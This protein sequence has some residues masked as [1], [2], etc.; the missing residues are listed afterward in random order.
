MIV[1]SLPAENEMM[2]AFLHRDASFDGIFFTGVRTTGIFCLPS[3]PARKPKPENVEFFATSRD[4]LFSGYRPCKRCRPMTPESQEPTWLEP[5]IEAIDRDPDRKWRD[6]DLEAMG[7]SPERA[8][9]W[10]QTVHGMTF[11]AYARARR[12]GRALAQIREGA[13]VTEAA[14]GNGFESLSGFGDAVRRMTGAPPTE[15]ESTPLIQTV[16][17]ETPVGPMMAAADEDSLLMLEFADRRMLEKQVARVSKALGGPLVPG[18]NAILGQLQDELDQYFAGTLH[19]FTLPLRLTGTPFQELVWQALLEIPY[20]TTTHYG[21]IAEKLGQPTAMRAVARA[22]GDNKLA[23]IIPCH[24]VI[25]KDG[26]LTGYGGGLW[27]KRK[28]LDHEQGLFVLAGET[29]EQAG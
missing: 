22:N 8:R 10:F 12:L 24:R 25:G 5:L 4:A 23:I 13:T 26:T 3:C 7:I 29:A 14:F 15:A 11:H 2:D 16:R 6:S 27:R 1:D 17:I 18:T 19:R 21:A 20:G 9:R 28:L